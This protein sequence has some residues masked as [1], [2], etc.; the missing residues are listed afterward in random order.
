MPRLNR[1]RRVVLAG[2]N[3]GALHSTAK[4]S[5]KNVSTTGEKR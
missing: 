5:F 1:S 4:K 3:A 2:S